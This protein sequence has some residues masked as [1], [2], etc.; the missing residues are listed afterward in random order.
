MHSESTG[1][2]SQTAGLLAIRYTAAVRGSERLYSWHDGVFLP[3]LARVP[4]FV[5]ADRYEDVETAEH[6]AL[7]HLADPW[8]VQGGQFA[9]AWTAGWERQRDGLAGWKRTLYVRIL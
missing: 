9:R 2:E 1:G 3:D 5:R 4:G 8:V 7:Y 6:L